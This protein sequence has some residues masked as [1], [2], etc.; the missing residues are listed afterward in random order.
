MV[1]KRQQSI[2]GTASVGRLRFG[3]RYLGFVIVVVAKGTC[4]SQRAEAACCPGGHRAVP[5]QVRSE[6][7][8][9]TWNVNVGAR[10]PG[11]N[12]AVAWTGPQG[13]SFSFDFAKFVS[14]FPS[15]PTSTPLPF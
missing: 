9:G 12:D 5:S 13:P 1:V 15:G 3:C 11:R 10:A 8:G 6:G 7:R 2:M 4:A 14:H